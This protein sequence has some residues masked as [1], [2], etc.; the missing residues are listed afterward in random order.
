MR[1]TISRL[2][3][4]GVATLATG[5]AT[6]AAAQPAA[7]G[8][9]PDLAMAACRQGVGAST[10][11]LHLDPQ[12]R[13]VVAGLPGTPLHTQIDEGAVIRVTAAGRI[14]YGGVFNWRG[15]WG[16]DGNGR[17]APGDWWWP[18]PSGPD[19]ALVG[20]WNQTP[21]RQRIGSDSGCL[22]VPRHSLRNAP[23]GLWLKANDDEIHDNG[24]IGYD[25]TVSAWRYFG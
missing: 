5:A 25:I 1:H 12:N 10:A 6:V 23:Y 13:S 9:R 18:Y 8:V 17:V 11:R 4:F 7:A 16:P 15:T 21:Q 22:F 19:A 2:L 20:Q 24:D 3:R 14:S